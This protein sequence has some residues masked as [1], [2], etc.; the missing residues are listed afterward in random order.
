MFRFK[1]ILLKKKTNNRKQKRNEKRKNGLPDVG[2]RP[3]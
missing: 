1:K 2:L 3:S